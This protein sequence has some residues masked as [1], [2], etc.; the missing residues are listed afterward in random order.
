[1]TF[2][3]WIETLAAAVVVV[4]A[5]WVLARKTI[6]RVGNFLDDWAGEPERR[7]VA[8]RAGVME[9][10]AAG[11]AKTDRLD[12]RQTEMLA[13][14]HANTQLLGT[15]TTQLHAI[16]AELHPNGGGSLRDDIRAIRRQVSTPTDG[17]RA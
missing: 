13:L 2:A 9:R 17:G 16:D 3:G 12:A 11:D 8:A 7:G 10:L 14:I 5:M 15:H 4:S 1:M 6:R